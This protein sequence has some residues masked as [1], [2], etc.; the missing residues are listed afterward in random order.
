MLSELMLRSLSI[1]AIATCI[2][3]AQKLEFLGLLLD[4]SVLDDLRCCRPNLKG[5]TTTMKLLPE[6]MEKT[7][8][9]W[10]AVKPDRHSSPRHRAVGRLRSGI[11]SVAGD[12]FTGSHDK[13]DDLLFGR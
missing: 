11:G 9:R 2:T 4:L 6:S 13:E 3:T 12:G 7:S 1:P 8:A 5:T 10:V